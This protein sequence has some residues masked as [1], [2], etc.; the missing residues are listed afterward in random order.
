MTSSEDVKEKKTRGRPKLL[1]VPKR[2]M[3]DC[4]YVK[5]MNEYKK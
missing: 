5:I 2:E 3:S 4:S 1:K